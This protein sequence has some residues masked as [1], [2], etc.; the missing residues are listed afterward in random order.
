MVSGQLPALH[1][2][3]DHGPSPNIDVS[4]L[5]HLAS[6][7]DLDIL[8]ILHV[9]IETQGY[10]F[11]LA[12]CVVVG[13][14]PSPQAGAQ[15]AGYWAGY[16]CSLQ[17]IALLGW[18]AD[19]APALT[20]SQQLQ[21]NVRAASVDSLVIM[22]L[23]ARSF[24]PCIA[25]DPAMLGQVTAQGE[26]ALLRWMLSQRA[27]RSRKVVPAACKDPTQMLL[28]A[29][30]HGWTVPAGMAMQFAEV[31]RRYFAFHG[32]VWK[33]RQGP[34]NRTCLGDLPDAVLMSIACRAGLDFSWTFST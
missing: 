23:A 19:L 34:A 21:L 24:R 3:Q 1:V 31:E 13:S 29:H 25:W 18:L 16:A 14:A 6:V 22:Q 28:L 26:L 20:H 15:A 5:L 10:A 33:H 7:G 11:Q 32:S 12:C 4:K 8:Q 17:H 27:T 2:L 9:Q 30:G